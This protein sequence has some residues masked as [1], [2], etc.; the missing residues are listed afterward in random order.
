VK[1]LF[2]IVGSIFIVLIVAIISIPLFVDVDQY[3][4][5]IV[6]EANKRING[7]LE[8]GKLKLNL[9]GA[10]KINAESIV[11]RVNSFKEPMLDT[12]SFHLEIP[13]MSVISG[14]PQIIAVLD[15]PKILVRK[16][17]NGKMNVLELMKVPGAS[18]EAAP[19]SLPKEEAAVT[20][21]V[22]SVSGAPKSMAKGKPALP[23]TPASAPVTVV[24]N[25]PLPQATGPGAPI[26]P[27]SPVEPTK[28]PALVAG[29]RIG[30]TIHK[31]EVHYV[32]VLAKSTYDVNGLDLDARNVGLGSMMDISLTA[33]LKGEMPN[34]TFSGPVSLDAQIMPL[35]FNNE[36]K[37]VKGKLNAD[38]TKLA[39]EM[40]GGTFHKSDKMP[41]TL[42]AE[43][44]GNE[45]ETL[46]RTF[47]LRFNNYQVHGKGRATA[48]PVSAQVEINTEPLRLNEL[49]EFVP[50]VAAY[51]LKGLAGL[52]VKVDYSPA[53]LRASGDANVKD[54][55]FFMKDVLKAPMEFQVKAGFTENSFDLVQASLTAPDSDLNVVGT[56]KNFLAPQFNFSLSGK[57]FNVDKALVLPAAAPA[58]TAMFSLISEAVADE[59]KGSEIN[60][61]LALAKNPMFLNAAGTVVAKLNRLT[62]YNA[63]F[64][65]VNAK[66]RLQNLVLYVTEASLKTFS[67]VVRANAEADLKAPALTYKTSGSVAGVS[68]KDAFAAYFP[69]YKNTLEGTTDANWN[70]SGAAY[71]PAARMRSIK[72]TAKL[73]AKDGAIKSVDFQGTINSTI[74]KVPFLKGKKVQVDDG[75]KTMTAD[76]RFDNGNITL[77]PLDMQPR[78]KG[79]VIK[80]KSVITENLEQDSYLDIF[81]PQGIL[82]KEFQSPGK[83]ALPLHLTGPIT[84]PKPDY[85]YTVKR[86]AG[87]VGKNVAKDQATKALGKFLGGSDKPGDAKQD[88]LKRGADQ[89]KKL[90]KF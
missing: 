47:E 17:A 88:A 34:M 16:E 6:A 15:A 24:N 56:V 35:L 84:G 31:G 51:D 49:Q 9:W 7:Q 18:A 38:A 30:V 14:K 66:V 23:S 46:I 81:D 11:V 8:L 74:A 60:P 5:Q 41:L 89:L 39:I 28:V 29:A 44:D 13:F 73:A 57:S 83:P 70:L 19:V 67:G 26:Q 10:I 80:G 71:P 79:F 90:F 77:D 69:K 55:S 42:R 40:K 62:A 61:M 36:V 76:L 54:G 37:S 1:K 86:I 50:M 72:G 64:D 21:Q 25:S 22:S 2:W 52:N 82:P 65:E 63:N 43:L 45:R 48:E 78:G 27:A 53:S 58:K 87:S 3:R 12:K 33:P 75:F 32:D 85:E 59:K 4:P 20:D 68:A